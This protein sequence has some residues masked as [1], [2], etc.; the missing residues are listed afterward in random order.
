MVIKNKFFYL[1]VALAILFWIIATLM[2]VFVFKTGGF[3]EEFFPI[4]DSHD[5]FIRIVVTN[6]AIFAGCI[7]QR[8]A[9]KL[10]LAYKKEKQLN[11]LLEESINEIKVLKEIL[12]ICSSCKKIRDDEGYWNNLEKYI[13]EHSNTKF[14]HGLCPECARKLYPEFYEN[15][16]TRSA[17]KK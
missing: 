3:K 2:H 4:H 14:T 9:N 1:S 6:I 10:V 16:K 5:L 17:I 11:E 8:M 15:L 7:S 13:S 12:P